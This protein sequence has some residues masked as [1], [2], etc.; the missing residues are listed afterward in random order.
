MVVNR[1]GKVEARIVKASRTVGNQWLIDDGL[2]AGDRVIVE[3][4]QRIQPGM[5]VKAVESSGNGIAEGAAAAPGAAG[6]ADGV[7]A[8][9]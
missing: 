7:G 4:L 9:H 2:V 3:G 8:A 1:D 5:A 6:A